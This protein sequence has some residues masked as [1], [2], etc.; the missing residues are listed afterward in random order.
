MPVGPP[1]EGADALRQH[2][3]VAGEH[4]YVAGEH[5]IRKSNLSSVKKTVTGPEAGAAAEAEFF[6]GKKDGLRDELLRTVPELIAAAQTTIEATEP[7]SVRYGAFA[8]IELDHVLHPES[9]IAWFR[10]Q[11]GLASPVM[12]DTEA[13]LL[14]CVAAGI[15]AREA[16]PEDVR[17]NRAALFINTITRRKWYDAL[18]HVQSARKLIDEYEREKA[19]ESIGR[20]AEVTAVAS[21]EQRND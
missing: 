18:P 6:G 20:R 14:L 4:T 10:A 15:M 13:D 2:R 17:K 5:H 21:G 16:R 12:Q 1:S 7:K 9:F 3:Y 19:S 11:L 8:S